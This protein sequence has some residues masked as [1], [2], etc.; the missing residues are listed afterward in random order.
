MNWL[1][2]LFSRGALPRLFRK[3]ADLLVVGECGERKLSHQEL[4]DSKCDALAIDFFDPQWYRPHLLHAAA[5]FCDIKTLL[6]GMNSDST[7]FLEAVRAGGRGYLLKC[8]ATDRLDAAKSVITIAEARV[9]LLD[10]LMK[11]A[12]INL[13]SNKQSCSAS[14]SSRSSLGTDFLLT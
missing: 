1:Q 11:M 13:L 2:R 5:E 4:L 7:I 9:T 10:R 6:I 14:H 3:S 12:P 8:C